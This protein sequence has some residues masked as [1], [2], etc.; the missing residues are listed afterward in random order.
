VWI[1]QNPLP[2]LPCE[3]LGCEGHYLSHSRCLDELSVAQ[4]MSAVDQALRS[5]DAPALRQAETTR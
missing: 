1:V 3:K 5:S 4:V 2:C